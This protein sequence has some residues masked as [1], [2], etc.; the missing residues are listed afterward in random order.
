MQWIT[1]FQKKRPYVSLRKA[2]QKR[3]SSQ[4]SLRQQITV[5]LC[6]VSVSVGCASS[7]FL[8]GMAGATHPYRYHYLRYYRYYRSGL[9]HVTLLEICFILFILTSHKFPYV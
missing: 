5:C 4:R 3:G 9:S 1:L 6:D 2:T 7:K 8:T